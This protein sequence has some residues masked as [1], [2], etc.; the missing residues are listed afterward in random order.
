MV[1]PTGASSGGA[2]IAGMKYKAVIIDTITYMPDNAI[3]LL[4]KLAKKKHLI[5]YAEVRRKKEG[6][7]LQ[8]K[9]D[10]Q[11][12]T[13][14]RYFLDPATATVTESPENETLHFSPHELKVLWAP[15]IK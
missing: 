9:A 1:V 3:T 7:W 11:T 10:R 12:A 15:G 5:I 13:G 14:N 2:V 4:K 6:G 8:G